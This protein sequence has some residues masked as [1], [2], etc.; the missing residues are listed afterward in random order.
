[1]QS[2]SI[3]A[4]SQ[5]RR[6][7]VDDQTQQ[8]VDLSLKCESLRFCHGFLC[9]QKLSLNLGCSSICRQVLLC[10]LVENAGVV[11]EA[12]KLLP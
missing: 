9:A 11:L 4:G 2:D 12:F 6:Y 10:D 3:L 8:L 1:M 5:Q 7:R